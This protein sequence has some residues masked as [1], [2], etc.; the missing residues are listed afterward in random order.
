M[1]SSGGGFFGEDPA[2]LASKLRKAEQETEDHAFFTRVEELL[3]HVLANANDRDAE[4]IAAH[5]KLIAQALEKKIDGVVDL[6]FG[7]SVAK[8]T[9]VEG[10]SDVDALVVV[11]DTELASKDPQAVCDY[12]QARL[13]ERLKDRVDADGFAV[14]VHFS[15]VTVQVIPVIRKG[16]DL[17]LPNAECT[18]WS[19]IRPSA[20]T[21]TLTDANKACSGKLVPTIKLAKVLLS[22]L[23]DQRRPSGYHLENLAVEAF[24][25]Y[26]GP[27]T[28]REMLHHFFLKA[29]TLVRTPIRDRTGQSSHVDDYLGEKTSLERLM[30][31]D[32]LARIGRR[33]LN[34]DGSK[35][36]EQWKRLM[37]M[38]P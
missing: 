30:V 33:L 2:K 23:P 21:K 13:S 35:D 26:K 7:G 34:A 22:D 29:S 11:N 36:L 6:L 10:M 15:D 38:E 17:L 28:P 8:N 3:A 31:T 9:Y 16:D 20:F 12:I 5:L 18:E 25:D 4:A 32:S 19:R 24:A 37:G 1:G 27:Y 14:N